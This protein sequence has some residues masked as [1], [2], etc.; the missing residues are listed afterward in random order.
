MNKISVSSSGGE[1]GKRQAKISQNS[2][3]I[4]SP[5]NNQGSQKL[6][7]QNVQQTGGGSTK[8]SG[9]TAQQQLGTSNT[10]NRAMRHYS[11]CPLFYLNIANR[12]QY[13]QQHRTPV[14]PHFSGGVVG[15]ASAAGGGSGHHIV[16]AHNQ[17]HHQHPSH[18][19][20]GSNKAS[21]YHIPNLFQNTFQ[22]PL[23]FRNVYYYKS[24]LNLN[25]R[26]IVLRPHGAG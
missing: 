18:H 1:S 19:H 17:P 11:N 9:K 25:M 13:Y 22:V 12:P 6:S 24:L 21:Y 8:S 4:N 16:A 15:G 20:G 3:N 14:G 5:E 26:L 2:V 7:S 10:A 23:H